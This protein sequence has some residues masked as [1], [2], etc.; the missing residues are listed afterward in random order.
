VAATSPSSGSSTQGKALVTIA[1]LALL[2]ATVG[3]ALASHALSS[4]DERALAAFSTA[5]DFEFFH[6]L[7]IIGV[8]ALGLRGRAGLVRAIAGWLMVTGLVLFCGSIYLAT[9]G[10]P[11]GITAV[12]PIGGVAFMAAWVALAVSPWLAGGTEHP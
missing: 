6:G 1:A 5:I 2:E 8:V 4:L 3:G 9:F 12:A 7:G 11:R 10:A